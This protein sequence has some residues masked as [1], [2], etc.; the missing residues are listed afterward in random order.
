MPQH[1]HTATVS[2]L[3]ATDEDESPSPQKNTFV[4]RLCDT[5]LRVN[6]VRVQIGAVAVKLQRR[7][8]H[9]IRKAPFALMAPSVAVVSTSP[10]SIITDA[11]KISTQTI[12]ENC[13]AST[14]ASTQMR[15]PPTV[16][17]NAARLAEVSLSL[18]ARAVNGVRWTHW[19]TFRP[20]LFFALMCVADEPLLCNGSWANM[21][22]RHGNCRDEV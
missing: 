4:G 19:T 20:M 15:R 9:S 10:A 1:C 13:A 7:T 2:S 8:R 6:T 22:V 3:R 14:T 11:D 5:D 21:W 12:V 16:Y 18:L 17:G